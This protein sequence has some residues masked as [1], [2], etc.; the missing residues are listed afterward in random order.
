MT[1]RST[2]SGLIDFAG[3]FERM[4]ERPMEPRVGIDGLQ[5]LDAEAADDAGP[6]F[7]GC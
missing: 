5:P 7:A 6:G 4:P 2:A 3:S 1:H